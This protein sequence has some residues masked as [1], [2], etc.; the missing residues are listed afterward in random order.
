MVQSFYQV[1]GSLSGDTALYVSRQAD[2]ELY[3]ALLAGEFCYVFNARQMGKSSLRTRVQQQLEDLGH[4][5]VYLDMTQLGSEEV[6][7]QQWYR[8]V[9]LELLRDLGLLGKVDIKAHWQTWETLPP[10]QQLQLL[11]DEI[12]S[13]LPDTRLFILVDEIDS[14]LSLEFPVNDFFAFIR[15]C[16]EQRQYQTDYRRLTWALFGVATPSDLIRDRKRT[17][18]NIGHAIDL[19]DFH[20][21]EARPLMAGFKDQVPNPDAILQAILDW[22]GGQ[23]LLTQKL[24]Q[25]VTQKSQSA[26]D[27]ALSLP[28]GAEV[29][30]IDELV[31]SDIIDHWEAQDNPEHLRTIRNRL[32]MDEQRIPRL[33]GLY[34]RILDQGGVPLD[35]SLEQTEL[36][37]SGLVCK[38]QGQLRVK[39][40][41]YQTIFDI[42]WI[43]QQLAQ[44]RP[45]STQL[46]GWLESG[47]TEPS[48]LLRGQALREAQAWG[49]DKSLSDVDYQFLQASQLA[50]QQDIQQKLEAERL[51]EANARLLQERRAA[52]LK[53]ILLGV[54]SVGFVGA[55]G[56]SLFAGRQYYA[57][58]LSEVKALASSSQGQFASNQQLNAMVDAIKAKQILQRFRFRDEETQSQVAAALNQAVFGINEVN[59]LTGHQGAV[60]AIDMSPDGRFI[61]TSSNDKTVKLWSRNGQLQGAFPHDSTVPSVAFSPDSQHIVTGSLNGQVLVW[62]LDGTLEQ[63]IQAHA[64]PIWSIAVSPDNQQ[65]MSSGGDKTVKLWQRDGTLAL[66]LPMTAVSWGISFSPN[67]QTL[68]AALMDGTVRLW[69]RQGELLQVL[70]GHQGGVWDVAFCPARE[71]TAL[72]PGDYRLVTVSADKTAK[73]WNKAGELL[74]TLPMA[75][76][77]LRGVDCSIDGQY[78]ATGGLDNQVYIWTINGA[79]VRLLEGHQS[80]VRN[81]KFSPDVAELVSIS[82]DGVVKVWRRNATFLQYLYGAEDTIWSI[83]TSRD[84]ERVVAA[85]GFVNQLLLWENFEPRLELRDTPLANLFA[86]AFFP[87]QPLLAAVGGSNVRLLRL[88]EGNQPRWTQLWERT[89]PTTGSIMSVAVSPD[90][91]SII[92]GSDEGRISVW[93]PQGELLHQLDTGNDRIWQINFQPIAD[94]SQSSESPL[95]ALAAAN[96]AV[97]LWRLDGTRVATLKRRGTAASWGA[98][99]SPDGQLIAAPSY[100]GK[101]RLWQLDGTLLFES[102]GNE[103]GLTRI[104]FSPDGQTIATG[105]INAV[106][107]LWNLDGTLQNTLVGH[108]GFISSL[109]YSSDGRYLF[110]GAADGQLIAWD[111]EKI[112]TLDPLE[113]ACRW[114]QDY[115]ATNEEVQESDRTLC[116]R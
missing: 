61:V 105:G 65:I 46:Q 82:Q 112:A 13:H 62:N 43:Q 54:A 111:L 107:K 9:M 39:N 57:A 70:Q 74:Q 108:E 49:Q 60:L 53:T 25:L 23:P 15:A 89:I 14:I 116:Q 67:G 21:E 36:Q 44:L 28:P 10:V 80:A 63:R 42:L 56:L 72:G 47:K 17:P 99:F 73:I 77:G 50:H 96:G 48:W 34:Q 22:T 29:A 104:A 12:L 69:S 103:R 83:A 32:L 79:F 94:S 93:T 58:K 97:E 68:A 115:L 66:T 64:G 92:S 81:V 5:C 27:A 102:Q 6:S 7:H 26:Q 88:E 38:R 4:R 84:Q 91:E 113:F 98:V 24:C 114:V 30:W 16:H 35:G 19:Q 45:Y 11:I 37:L 86:V 101:L 75:E 51:K 41:I 76:A 90:G 100:D 71:D 3:K 52:R 2:Q 78:I 106:V 85:S 87:N 18:F 110:S 1:G 33:L 95:F 8:G 31:Q 55:L 59:R 20:L 40:R 109:A